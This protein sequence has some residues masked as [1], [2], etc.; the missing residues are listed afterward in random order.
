MYSNGNIYNRGA[1]C[2]LQNIDIILASNVIKKLNI[3][4]LYNM[5]KE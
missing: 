3:L 2:L 5:C 1:H 4:S